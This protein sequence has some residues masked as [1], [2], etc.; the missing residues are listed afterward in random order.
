MGLAEKE[1]LPEG[2]PPREGPFCS[3]LHHVGIPPVG[4]FLWLG[5]Q[6]AC[7]CGV[8]GQRQWVFLLGRGGWGWELRKCVGCG[9]SYLATTREVGQTSHLDVTLDLHHPALAAVT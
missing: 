9:G 1:P 6:D 8:G 2:P 7:A 3:L 4:V 5:G